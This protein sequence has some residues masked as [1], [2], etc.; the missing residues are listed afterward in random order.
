MHDRDKIVGYLQ[1]MYSS[2]V[3][4]KSRAITTQRSLPQFFGST[5]ESSTC[6]TTPWTE[7]ATRDEVSRR[8]AAC[9]VDAGVI[10]HR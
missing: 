6:S 2:S 5:N 1:P 10:P 4:R 3:A 7:N 9:G 8:E